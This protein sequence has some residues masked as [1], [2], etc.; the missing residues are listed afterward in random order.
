MPSNES[1]ISALTAVLD[2]FSDRATA[3]ASFFL[4]FLFGLF[5]ILSIVADQQG[6][7][8]RTEWLIPYWI[9][10]A[11]G[12]YELIRFNYYATYAQRLMEATLELSGRAQIIYEKTFSKVGRRLTWVVEKKEQITGGRFWLIAEVYFI[13]AFIPCTLAFQLCDAAFSV[14]ISFTIVA[15]SFAVADTVAMSKA[16]MLAS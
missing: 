5:S 11:M 16:G 9:L 4:A 1:A 12:L 2:F 14:V 15:L 7:S 10:F 3:H 13:A 8:I 6:T